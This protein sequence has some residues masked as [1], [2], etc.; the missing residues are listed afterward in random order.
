MMIA[1]AKMASQYDKKVELS[2]DHAMCCGV[3]ACYACVVK[4]KDSETPDKG[5][6]YARTCREGPVFSSDLIFTG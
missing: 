5:W 3:G 2:L 1:I 6:K 4:I